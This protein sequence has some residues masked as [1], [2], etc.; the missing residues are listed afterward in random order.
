RSSGICG[1]TAGFGKDIGD[2]PG[3]APAELATTDVTDGHTRS[4]TVLKSAALL[5][6][7]WRGRA[8]TPNGFGILRAR[9]RACTGSRVG[10]IAQPTRADD[11]RCLGWPAVGA[12]IVRGAERTWVRR[13]VGRAVNGPRE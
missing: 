3:V 13:G 5:R 7:G 4:G 10:A 9:N 11:C 6:G 1:Y 12:R 2:Q 8:S